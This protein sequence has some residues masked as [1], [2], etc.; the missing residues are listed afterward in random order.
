ML[1]DI[2]LVS[3]PFVVYV[4]YA[5]VKAKESCRDRVLQAFVHRNIAM[6]NK[7]MIKKDSFLGNTT[8]VIPIWKPYLL[9]KKK[10][11]LI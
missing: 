7:I 10:T 1:N 4:I 11:L 3:L 5:R 9:E 6:E 2:A 8:D